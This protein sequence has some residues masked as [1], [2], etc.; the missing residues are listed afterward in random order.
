MTKRALAGVAKVLC[1]PDCDNEDDTVSGNNTENGKGKEHSIQ[2]DLKKESVVLNA[3]RKPSLENVQ[4]VPAL[5]E[6]IKEALKLV[7]L[8]FWHLL[9]LQL[10]SCCPLAGL[11]CFFTSTM[12]KL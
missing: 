6:P 4:L 1:H 9:H 3:L 10:F 11:F 5:K 2:L 7:S 8:T 12:N